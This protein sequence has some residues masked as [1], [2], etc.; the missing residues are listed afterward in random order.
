[1]NSE[2]IVVIISRVGTRIGDHGIVT[3]DALKAIASQSSTPY[4]I[5]REVTMDLVWDG[6]ADA[7]YEYFHSPQVEQE[8]Q[9]V[10]KRAMRKD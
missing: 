4:I 3:E 9:Q 6:P 8:A 7:Y 1:M 2:R 5:Y 10:I